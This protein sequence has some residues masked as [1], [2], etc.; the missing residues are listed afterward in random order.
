MGYTVCVES[1]V[2]SYHCKPHVFQGIRKEICE[3]TRGS[4]KF[5]PGLGV[6]GILMF[7]DGVPM[8]IF[9]NFTSYINLRNLKKIGG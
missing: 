9:G 3:N 8:H 7:A 2:L 5:F 1:K 4:R 6:R